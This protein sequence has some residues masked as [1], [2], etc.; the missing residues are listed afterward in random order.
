MQKPS[1]LLVDDNVDFPD[2]LLFAFENHKFQIFTASDGEEALVNTVK[3]RPDLIVLD[4]MLHK[5]DGYAV[6]HELKTDKQTSSILKIVLTSLGKKNAGKGGAELLANG[7][8]AEGFMEK[9]V[10]P[11]MLVQKALELIPTNT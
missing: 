10:E 11:E 2:A 1:V 6:C 7:H 4:I 5:K 3:S 8:D 9:P